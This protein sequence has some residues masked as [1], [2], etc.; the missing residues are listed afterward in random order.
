MKSFKAIAAMSK[1]RVIGAGNKI[2]WHLPEDF[3]W[4]KKMPVGQIEGMK[5]NVR[6]RAMIPIA[7]FNLRALPRRRTIRL[8]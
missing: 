2:P 5:Y 4:F 1:N 7:K 3:K 6:G 8:L